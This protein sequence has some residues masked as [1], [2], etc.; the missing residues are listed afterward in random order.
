MFG[1]LQKLDAVDPSNSRMGG[2][3]M[4]GGVEA[5]NPV[6]VGSYS[7]RASSDAS[8]A[9]DVSLRIDDNETILMR[10]DNETMPFGIGPAAAITVGTPARPRP[11][12]K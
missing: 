5:V 8:G 2:V 9:F 4:Q 12:G 7:L 10:S 11:A 3:L 1:A 6:Y